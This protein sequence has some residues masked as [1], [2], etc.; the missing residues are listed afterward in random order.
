MDAMNE[1]NSVI[2][3][4]DENG[5]ECEFDVMDVVELDGKEYAVLIALD[6]D[7]EE[8][9]DPELIIL[10]VVHTPDNYVSFE[11]IEDEAELDSVFEVFYSH[12]EMSINAMESDDED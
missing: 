11:K 7:V 10:R 5:N 9:L 1:Y 4:T 6:G 8:E 2:T 3:L 12:V